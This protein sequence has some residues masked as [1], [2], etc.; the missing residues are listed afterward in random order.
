MTG[1]MR[2]STGSCYVR[3][4]S[5]HSRTN[6]AAHVTPSI[7]L[8]L[9]SSHPPCQGNLSIPPLTPTAE[10]QR[11]LQ[12]VQ[13][14]TDRVLPPNP[15]HPVEDHNSYN[16]SCTSGRQNVRTLRPFALGV[17]GRVFQGVGV[18]H[19]V[20]VSSMTELRRSAFR[21]RND[22]HTVQSTNPFAQDCMNEHEYRTDENNTLIAVPC[23][24]FS[25]L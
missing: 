23:N 1:R 2:T 19:V 16:D 10:L 5:I 12:P 24:P 8:L 13:L 21:R 17:T 3:S 7:I 25:T 6:A 18:Q 9:V 15:P 14:R 22:P 20:G 4:L 11:D